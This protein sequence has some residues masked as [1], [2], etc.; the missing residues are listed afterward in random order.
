MLSHAVFIYYFVLLKADM[1]DFVLYSV[2]YKHNKAF[3]FIK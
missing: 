2:Q 1:L 3:D